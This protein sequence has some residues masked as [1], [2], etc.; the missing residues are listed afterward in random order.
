VVFARSCHLPSGLPL[1]AFKRDE[2]TFI[3]IRFADVGYGSLAI[4]EI[5]IVECASIMKPHTC[6][7]IPV[8]KL[9]PIALFGTTVVRAERQRSTLVVKEAVTIRNEI[10]LA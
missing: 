1:P 3:K 8:A 4:R 5:E 6:S 2:A 9:V 7:R 10:C